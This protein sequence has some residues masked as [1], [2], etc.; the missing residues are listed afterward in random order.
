MVI[1]M[2]DGL[3]IDEDILELHILGRLTPNQSTIVVTHCAE[4]MQCSNKE[5][6]ER[7]FI[8][9]MRSLAFELTAMD[10]MLCSGSYDSTL[11]D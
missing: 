2:H 11:I 7:E 8:R 3:H 1:E 9:L 10:A 5:A 4:C 6:E